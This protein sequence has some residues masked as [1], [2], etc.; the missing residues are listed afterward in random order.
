MKTWNEI[1]NKNKNHE[2]D[3]NPALDA[4]CTIQEFNLPVFVKKLPRHKGAGT[5]G[6]VENLKKTNKSQI[7]EKKDRGDF[8]KPYSGYVFHP[9]HQID[10]FVDNQLVTENQW[11]WWAIMPLNLIINDIAPEPDERN[12]ESLDWDNFEQDHCKF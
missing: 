3:K 5:F 10:I 1:L 4:A 12:E 9:H 11:R 2:I 6:T 8:Y 7:K